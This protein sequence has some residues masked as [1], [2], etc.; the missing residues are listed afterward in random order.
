MK[1]LN[2][3]VK[4]SS[5]YKASNR[6]EKEE[7]L[8]KIDTMFEKRPRILKYKNDIKK[9]VEWLYDNKENYSVARCNLLLYKTIPMITF[10]IKG[11]QVDVTFSKDVIKFSYDKSDY[12]KVEDYIKFILTGGLDDVVKKERL[13]YE[14]CEWDYDKENGLDR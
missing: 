6:V 4:E 12:T 5:T 14:R 11:A 7:V 13:I 3:K 1:P 2:S 10:F 8:K 9:F